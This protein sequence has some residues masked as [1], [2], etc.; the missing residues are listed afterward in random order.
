[1]KITTRYGNV[2]TA[3]K[4]LPVLAFYLLISACAFG[5]G[6]NLNVYGAYVFDD[7]FDSYY[8]AGNYYEGTINGGF[9][10]G[11]GVEYSPMDDYGIELLYIRQDTQAPTRYLGGG[12]I[13][14]EVRTD[15]NLDMNYV[16]L[17]G[18]RY[19]GDSGGKLKG[20]GGLLIG[21][22]FAGLENPDTGR[23]SSAEKFALGGRIGGVFWGSD[24]VGLRVQAMLL[25]A[26]Q[27]MGGGFYFGTGG[28]GA[29]LS[30]YSTIYQFSLG[31]GLVFKVK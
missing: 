23:S 29:G 22:A 24:R 6:V 27:S 7:R 8:D 2:R 14:D 16:V 3:M 21:V 13:Q 9:Q 4:C 1:M 28:A 30:S 26:V 18:A 10:W 15:F 5:Q 20:F 25:S 31:G 11:V 19:F 12:I 17:G